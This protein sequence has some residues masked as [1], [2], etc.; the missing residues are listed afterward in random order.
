MSWCSLSNH[1]LRCICIIFHLNAIYYNSVTFPCLRKWARYSHLLPSIWVFWDSQRKNYSCMPFHISL[2][3]DLFPFVWA[4]KHNFCFRY[5][6]SLFIPIEFLNLSHW[7]RRTFSIVQGNG[8]NAAK[9]PSICESCL[10]INSIESRSCRGICIHN[11]TKIKQA[12][13]R[14]PMFCL[15]L[16]CSCEFCVHTYGNRVW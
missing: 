2:E 12:R 14:L 7:R 11:V 16:K 3:W 15:H 9:M 8:S 5:F 1:V 6:F 4:S 10:G 13:K